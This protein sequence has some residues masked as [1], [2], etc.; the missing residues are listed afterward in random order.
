M[1]SA[2]SPPAVFLSNQLRFVRL[3]RRVGLPVATTQSLAY[4]RGLELIDLGVREQVSHTAR[5]LLVTRAE[6]L[7]LFDVVFERFW[8]RHG[9]RSWSRPSLSSPGRPSRVRP[10]PV[11]T[12]EG[13]AEDPDLE[14]VADRTGRFSPEEVLRRK[15]FAEMSEEELDRVRRLVGALRW[16]AAERRTRRHRPDPTGGRLSLRAMLRDAARHGG[17]PLRLRWQRP[18]VR[19]R[20]LVL[21]A[22]VSGSMERYSRIVLQFL[23]CVSQGLPTVD[24]FVFGTRLTR[25]TDELGLRNADRALEAA[26][27]RVLDF[28][29]GTRIGESL[30]HFN[31]RWSRRVLSR[32]AVV[33]IISDGWDRGDI[34]GLAR[35]MRF[36]Q[37]RS[38]RLIWLNP[39]LGR[40]GYEP[41]VAGMS[42]AL[43]FVDDFLPVHN[44]RSLEQLTDHLAALPSRRSVQRRAVG[45]GRSVSVAT[46]G[47]A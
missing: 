44:L 24:S 36:L 10:V 18:K 21:L 7:A 1:T 19:P 11:A 13:R 3:L 15:D 9:D 8:R 41:L 26:T 35:E 46:R 20:P 37:H 29:G 42:T 30:A 4:L 6:D 47:D 32:G 16:K 25:V 27:R 39:L 22:D 45:H 38:H 28:A 43:P 31:R 14:E 5:S 23:Y 40:P 2:A 33:V 34:A 17:V 12:V